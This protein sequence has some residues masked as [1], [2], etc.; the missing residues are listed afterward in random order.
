MVQNVRDEMYMLTNAVSNDMTYLYYL[1][2]KD[3]SYLRD[4]EKPLSLRTEQTVDTLEDWFN[5]L[6]GEIW[7]VMH[8]TDWEKN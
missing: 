1:L 3:G 7:K 6:W 8:T 5:K 4:L 2:V